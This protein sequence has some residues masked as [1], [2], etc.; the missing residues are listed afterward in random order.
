MATAAPVALSLGIWAVTGS[1]YALL[2]AALGPVVAIGSTFDARR[3]RRASVRRELVATRE[4]LQ[5]T[6]ERIDEVH[7]GERQRREHLAP[8][9]DLA[10]ESRR[11]AVN[12][13]GASADDG[14]HPVRI[15]RAD[16]DPIVELTGEHPVGSET[17]GAFAELRDL[18]S[19]VRDAPWLGDARDGIGVVGPTPAAR[20]VARSLVVQLLA[21]LSPASTTLDAPDEEWWAAELPHTVRFGGNCYRLRS[22]RGEPLV[23]AWGATVQDLPPSVHSVIAISHS[24]ESAIGA[25]ERGEVPDAVGTVRA[26]QLARVLA[27]IADELGIAIAG[28]GLPESVSLADLLRDVG[29]PLARDEGLRAP[30]GFGADG[31]VELDL[32]RDGPHAVIAGTTGTGKSELLVSWVLSMAARHAPSAATFLLVDFKGGAAFAP[33]AGLP[34][35]VGIV[36][37]LD[38]RRSRR[39]IESL[40]AELRRRELLLAENGVRSVDELDGQ[41]ARLVIVVDE[42]AAVVSGQPEL[43]DVFSDLAA[44]GRSLGLHLILCTQHPSGVIRDG[45]LANVTLRI[46]LRVTDRADSVAMI[47][48][49]AAFELPPSAR[50]RALVADGAG[51]PREVQLALADEAVAA[52]VESAGGTR[53]AAVWCDPL[54]ERV[55]LDAIEKPAIGIPFGRFDL[56]DEQSQP[57]ASYDPE[58]DGHLL[59]LG[60]SRAGRTTALATL[61]VD[62]RCRVLPSHPAEAWSVLTELAGRA[63]ASERLVV[64]I[65]DLDMLIDRFDEDVRH[66]FVEMLTRLARE[67]RS[68]GLIVSAQRV[69]GAMQRLVGLFPSRLLLRQVSRDEHVLSGGE[70]GSFDPALTPGAGTWRGRNGKVVTV[71]VAIGD[72]PLPEATLAELPRVRLQAGVSTAIVAGRPRELL[73]VLSP[74]AGGL[75]IVTVGDPPVSDIEERVPPR[76]SRGEPRV[77]LGDPEAWQA[78]WALL[79]SVRRELPLVF[80]GC[81]PGEVRVMARTR[82]TPPP[83][84]DR[85]GECW[86]VDGGIARRAILE[87]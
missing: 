72:G 31:V 21:Q 71:Q 64:V 58:A 66:D 86:L 80:Y 48:S 55:P 14:S 43:H 1:V 41:L 12:W 67:S 62:P 45:V 18:A 8:P 81:T 50:G 38:A 3:Q 10:V 57:A 70:G 26:A 33:L 30:I 54:P 61:A 22:R 65:D 87:F 34:H 52:R 78:D 24:G 17:D 15:G 75:H 83:L 29:A 32:V 36:T 28:G 27:E 2:F 40:R 23:I 76:T 47:G 49:A 82:D 35:L 37:D 60:A 73:H 42:F 7:R 5:R 20:S 9:A 74:T 63:V 13:A 85:V 16:L 53:P 77:L 84:G 6:R 79:A 44:R 11:V 51:V 56:P 4:A 39:A 46:S 25:H 69:T 19:S 68:L 59:V